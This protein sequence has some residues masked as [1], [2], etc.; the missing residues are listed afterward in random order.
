MHLHLHLLFTLWFLLVLIICSVLGQ[1]ASSPPSDFRSLLEFKKGIHSDPSQRVSRSWDR[2]LLDSNG[3]PTSWFGIT[4]DNATGSVV[5]IALDGLGLTGELKLS[6]LNPLRMLQNLTLSGNFLTGR[7]VPTIGAIA[8]LQHLDL[9]GNQF[10]GP[11]P[12]RIMDLW[13]L[14]YLNL[15]S[16]KFTGRFPVGIRNLQQLRVLDLHSNSLSGDIGALLS[17]LRNVEY[18]DVSSN[19]FNGGI[20]LDSQNLS[21]LANTV[22][23]VNLSS[24]KLVGEL[25]SD[26]SIQL[27]RNLAVLDVS[28]NQ[29]TGK[30]PLFGSLPSLRVLR[31]GNNQLNGSI[32]AEIFSSSIPLGELDLSSNG[33]S[34]SVLSFN[35]TTLKILNLSSNTLSSSLPSEL[36]NCVTVDLSKNMLHGDLSSIQG[37]GDMLE[38]IDLSSNALSGSFPDVISHFTRLSSIKIRNN[39]LVGVLPAVLGNLPNL[40]TIDLSINSLNGTI[41]SS[42]FTSLALKN[43]HLSGNLLTGT[44]PIQRSDT[45]ESIVIPSNLHMESLD[46]SDN[47]LIGALPPGVG[48]MVSLKF[49]NLGKNRLSGQI[50]NEIS[51]LSELEYL[52]LSG[53]N[54]KGRIP[55]GLSPNLKGFN[56]SYNNLSGPIPESLRKFP[57][58]SFRPGNYLLI[59]PIGMPASQPEDNGPEVDSKG[60]RRHTSNSNVKVAIIV[61]SVG[62]F[63]IIVF[64]LLAY[65]RLRLVEPHGRNVFSGQSTGRDVK[66]GRFTRPTLF[67]LQKNADPVPASLSFSADQLLPSDARSSIPSRK[68]NVTEITECGFP[69]EKETGSESIMSN[70]PDSSHPTTGRKS[71][72]GSPSSSSHHFIGTRMQEQPVTLSVYSPDRLVGELFFLDNSLVFT[73]E[74][75][76]SAPAEV[77]GR[78]CHGTSYKAALDSSH[79]L[80]VKWLRVGLVKHKKEFSKE[81][82]R[83]GTIRHP[84]IVT[85][86]G[87]YWGP[88]EQERLILTDYIHGDSLALHLYE[89]TPRRYSPLSFSQR[90]KI[91]VDIARCLYY[92][93]D[94][95]LPHGNLKPTNILLSGSDFSAKLTDYGLHRLMTPV[96][97]AEQILNLGALGYRAP[98]LANANKPL[99]SFKA[100]V[101]SFGVILMELLTRRSAGDIISGQPDAVDLTDWVRLFANEGRG[102]DCLDRDIACVEEAP[103]AMDELLAISLRCILPVN[104][105]PNIRTIYEELCSITV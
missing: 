94:K 51:K 56:V 80:T 101:Y 45:I 53:N 20:R 81:A 83:I 47:S 33:F 55:D 29:L 41:P 95:G 28:Y 86:R 9:S 46:L 59:L 38:N 93:H 24:N 99:P 72:P 66:L 96:G 43:L 3:F 70:V 42:F 60:G 73:A 69:E 65:Y 12:G 34:G 54:F 82:K 77:L 88:R 84:N 16:N 44:I 64:V 74:E 48:N 85:V 39:S 102:I 57:S 50:P 75:L 10:Y 92:L 76:S 63:M 15:S 98:E 35:S 61:G 49:L 5:S 91:A 7:V 62:A 37:W 25:F 71:S 52:D 105:R 26:E 18:V 104:E 78:S 6:T 1:D 13:G 79:T 27:F 19:L 87:Y 36:G 22:R 8:S 23:Y 97:T 2:S 14:G 67:K 58:T 89:T 100:D 4:C 11:I 21:S 32:P 103:K 17:E 90:L 31:V 30:L 68:E 40:T